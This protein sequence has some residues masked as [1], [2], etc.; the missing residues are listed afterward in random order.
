MNLGPYL[1][2]FFSSFSKRFYW[3]FFGKKSKQS[4]D[5]YFILCSSALLLF[6]SYNVK[7]KTCDIC[8]FLFYSIEIYYRHKSKIIYLRKGRMICWSMLTML[9]L[10]SCS[11]IIWLVLSTFSCIS[12]ASNHDSNTFNNYKLI[13]SGCVLLHLFS[14]KPRL[15]HL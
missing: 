7:K 13:S 5:S 8:S 12:L 10:R 2:P 6:D 1:G 4:T 11:R 3:K 14:V 15:K 9:F